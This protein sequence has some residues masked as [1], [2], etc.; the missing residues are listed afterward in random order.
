MLDL[1]IFKG[2]I[3]FVAQNKNWPKSHGFYLF[4]HG[5]NTHERQTII[6]NNAFAANHSGYSTKQ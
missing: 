6:Q 4:L 5:R 2:N 1:Q 3:N